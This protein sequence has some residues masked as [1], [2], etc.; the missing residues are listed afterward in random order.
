[1]DEKYK[2]DTNTD[3][4]ISENPSGFDAIKIIDQKYFD[5]ISQNK[6]SSTPMKDGQ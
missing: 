2:K 5:S 3:T 4:Y 1:M 6:E